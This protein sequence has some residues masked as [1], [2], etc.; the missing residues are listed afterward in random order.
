MDKRQTPITLEDF[1]KQVQNELIVSCQAQPNEPLFGADIMVRMA[2]AA[3]QGGAKAIRANTPVDI[4]AIAQEID[5]PLIGL[6]KENIEGYPVYI[7]PT[8]SHAL[9]VAEAG[10]D[11]IAID[12]T[13]QKR[14]GGDLKGFIEEI[15]RK[16]GCLVMADIS[17]YE[18]GIQAEKFAVDMISTTLSGYTPYSLQQEGPNLDLVAQL[19]KNCSIPVIAEGRYHTPEQAKS[20]LANGATSVVIGGAITRPQQITARFVKSIHS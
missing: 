1:I 14:P 7:T 6:Y 19:A 20:A 3:Q 10:A 13:G 16:T 2:R 18:E 15:H 11:V 4:Q 9:A 12:A 17:T 5:L 8:I